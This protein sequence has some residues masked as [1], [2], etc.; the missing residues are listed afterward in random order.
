LVDGSDGTTDATT[1]NTR[2]LSPA[3]IRNVVRQSV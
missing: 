3:Q 2:R 1:M